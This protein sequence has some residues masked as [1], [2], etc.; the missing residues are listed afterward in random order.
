M[1]IVGAR[2]IRHI[3]DAVAELLLDLLLRVHEL[4]AQLVI[5]EVGHG[6]VVDRMR[7]DGDTVLIHLARLIP[8]QVVRIDAEETRDDED[9]RLEIVFLQDRIGVLVVVL[10][11]VVERDEHGILRQLR[12]AR[13]AVVE[14]IRRDRMVAVLAQILHLPLEV[15]RQHGER[16]IHI[17]DFVVIEHEHLGAVLAARDHARRHRLRA[18]EQ[19]RDR[20]QQ[21]EQQQSQPPARTSLGAK[22]YHEDSSLRNHENRLWR[23][24]LR[25]T[26]SAMAAS[27]VP[28]ES[29]RP[30][31]STL[32]GSELR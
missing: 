26:K 1:Q 25:T 29:S 27:S 6:L 19:E 32:P 24:R 13:E 20:E 9:R 23:V 5:R 16:D 22:R 30:S 17:V 21:H 8:G 3:V 10:I 15:L 14:L 18:R 7:L 28:P 4:N 31:G 2:R 12:I 11:A